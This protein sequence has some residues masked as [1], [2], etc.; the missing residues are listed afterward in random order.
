MAQLR[1]PKRLRQKYTADQYKRAMYLARNSDRPVAAIARENGIPPQTLQ[2]HLRNLHKRGAVGAPKVYSDE[3]E[4]AIIQFIFMR[5]DIHRPVT[6]G[7]LLR[8]LDLWM[9]MEQGQ[10][11]RVKKRSSPGK[12]SCLTFLP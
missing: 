2:D 12:K 9:K 5:A 3:E 6:R 4:N 1:A 8:H 10:K 11:Q 7:E